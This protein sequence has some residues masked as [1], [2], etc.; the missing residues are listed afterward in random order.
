MSSW[1]LYCCDFSSVYVYAV[2]FLLSLS[3]ALLAH[4]AAEEEGAPRWSHSGEGWLDVH[5]LIHW[6]S[7]SPSPD[8]RSTHSPPTHL[9]FSFWLLAFLTAR[10][11]R[12]SWQPAW[13]PAMMMMMMLMTMT[14]T[15]INSCLNGYLARC[16]QFWSYVSALRELDSFI[17]PLALHHLIAPKRNWATSLRHDRKHEKKCGWKI[18]RCVLWIVPQPN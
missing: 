13:Q 10:D 4:A 11:P 2:F 5:H 14:K 18:V 8:L 1:Q 17:H 6:A 9:T 3:S 16:L 15:W 7:T 12:S